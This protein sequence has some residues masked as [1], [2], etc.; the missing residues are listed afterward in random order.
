MALQLPKI[1]PLPTTEE[2]RHVRIVHVKARQG[3]NL[4]SGI[5]LKNIRRQDQCC[6]DS[7]WWWKY[8]YQRST[9]H[10]MMI[11]VRGMWFLPLTLYVELGK[12]M[13]RCSWKQPSSIKWLDKSTTYLSLWLNGVSRPTSCITKGSLSWLIC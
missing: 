13:K 7:H 6:G 11:V 8:K 4:S 1:E 5:L 3:T 12:L 10:N 2:M 9:S